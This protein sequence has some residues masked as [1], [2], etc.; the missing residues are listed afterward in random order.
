MKLTAACVPIAALA[1]GMGAA[2]AGDI[3]AEIGPARL[4]LADVRAAIARVRDGNDTA[5][6]LRTFTAEG[7]RE[8]VDALVREQLLALGARRRGLD[9]RPEVRAAIDR[10][11][12]AVLAAEMTRVEMAAADV[13]ESALQAYY[14][15]HP[16]EFQRRGRVK[17]RHIL[18]ASRAEAEAIRTALAGGADF[19]QLAR[20]RSTDLHS[21]DKG[22][23][24][25]WI[26]AG[27]MVKAFED[28]L[29]ALKAGETSAV[30]ES[31][32]GFHVVRADEV[33]RPS[34]P[35]FEAVRGALVR[36]VREAHL[37][38]VEERLKK[39]I[40]VKVFPEA[41]KALER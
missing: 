1:F 25:G 22:G 8:I 23:D 41:L 6:T 27:V 5:A 19:A 12:T 9:E 31:G 34:I 38:A 24:L 21:R 28:A 30:I 26:P 33:E 16:A 40:P 14:L 2:L 15:A 18:L 29:F 3:V 11:V 13:S 17:A 36:R 35:S 32:Y 39:D 7:Q 10:A 4:S 37:S 20:T